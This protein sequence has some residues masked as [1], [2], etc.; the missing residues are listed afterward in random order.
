M[1]PLQNEGMTTQA[2]VDFISMHFSEHQIPQRARI[3]LHVPSFFLKKV[4]HDCL[5]PSGEYLIII[6]GGEGGQHTG[7][8]IAICSLK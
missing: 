5:C 6:V 7:T 2:A 1:A 8:W 4:S 3:Q